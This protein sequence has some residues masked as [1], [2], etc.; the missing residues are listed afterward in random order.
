MPAEIMKYY[1]RVIKIFP[2]SLFCSLNCQIS[3]E[4]ARN[5]KGLGGEPSRRSLSHPMMGFIVEFLV[6]VVRELEVGSTKVI[7]CVVKGFQVMKRSR[8]S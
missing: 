4:Q 7:L 3:Q 8:G 6:A 2:Y 5:W 1:V